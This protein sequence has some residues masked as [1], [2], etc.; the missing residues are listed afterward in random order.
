MTSLPG[1]TAYPFMSSCREVVSISQGCL[2]SSSKVLPNIQALAPNNVPMY[3][4]PRIIDFGTAGANHECHERKVP[5]TPTRG[6]Y[7][8]GPSQL[9]LRERVSTWSARSMSSA[10]SSRASS[11]ESANGGSS[12]NATQTNAYCGRFQFPKSRRVQKTPSTLTSPSEEV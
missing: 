11:G 3:F 9:T 2:N 12:L 10:A 1:F 7:P 4:R 6:G 5:A 8:S